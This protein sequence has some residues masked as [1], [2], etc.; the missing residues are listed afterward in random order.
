MNGAREEKDQKKPVLEY[1]EIWEDT[2][3]GSHQTSQSDKKISGGEEEEEREEYK[4]KKDEEGLRGRG[5]VHR[6][7]KVRLGQVR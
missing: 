6:Q 1:G 2:V 3:C 7:F 5:I 4:R